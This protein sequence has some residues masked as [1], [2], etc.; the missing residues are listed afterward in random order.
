MV[1]QP[2][3]GVIRLAAIGIAILLLVACSTGPTTPGGTSGDSSTKLGLIID[4]NGPLSDPFFGAVKLGADAAA[5]M[6]N[7]EYQYS[8][9]ASV[10][11]FVPDYTTL[12]NQAVAR[13]PAAIVIA[14]LVPSAF[15]PL[16]KKITAAGTPVV[17]MQS[18]LET[19]QSDGAL[20]FVGKSYPST[21]RA[22]G[23]AALKTGVHHLLCVNSAPTNPSLGLACQAAKATMVAAGG[24]GVELDIPTVNGSNI[25]ALTQDIQGYLSSHSD[26]DGIFTLGSPVAVGAVAAVKNLGKSSTITVGTTNVST[27]VLQDVKSG[28]LAWVLDQQG[29]L[30]GFVSLQIAAQYVKYRIYPT[31]PVL[32]DGL[33]ITKSNVDSVLAVQ[34]QYPGVRGGA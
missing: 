9:P 5:K 16:I 28:A 29:Y 31:S 1:D 26:I 18:G 20:A 6:F 19:W 22:A 21:G 24:T 10:A 23:E 4:L 11:N 13:H 14:N 15:D 33:I 2:L 12:I 8:A 17:V 25:A 3:R 30:Q 7:I 27:Q 32:T 34:S